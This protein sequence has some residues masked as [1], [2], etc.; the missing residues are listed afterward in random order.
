MLYVSTRSTG[1]F[2][3][4]HRALNE[5]RTPDG[6]Y[7]VP[8]RLPVFT[9]SELARTREQPSA[10]VIATIL[11]IFFGVHVTRW[12]VECAIGRTPIKPIALTH[13]LCLGDACRNPGSSMDYMIASLHRTLT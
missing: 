4:A 9:E 7:F 13:N 8:H 12:D 3:T 5:A 1:D 6:G 11:N 10:E 2:Y